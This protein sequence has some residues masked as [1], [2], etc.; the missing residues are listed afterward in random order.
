M[1]QKSVKTAFLQ[2]F[3]KTKEKKMSK[4]ICIEGKS[5]EIV[6][7]KSRFIADVTDIVSEQN[8]LDFIEA[9]KKRYWDARHHCF[10]Y[11]TLDGKTV[12]C[13]D[14]GEPQGTA[15]K[16]MLEVLQH[17]RIAGIC[18]V[19]TRYFGGVL[20]GTGGLI[21]AYQSALIAGLEESRILEEKQGYRLTFCI[22]YEDYG[23]F[24]HLCEKYEIIRESIV[25]TERITIHLVAE[26]EKRAGFLRSLS[27]ESSGKLVPDTEEAI[28]YVA[29]NG[30]VIRMENRQESSKELLI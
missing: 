10:A 26:E 20:L 3:I 19:V 25:Y 13:S 5:G 6:E 1:P 9:V 24:N 17:R 7:K 18:V 29:D 12:R 16:P 22:G 23:R 30:S 21:R 8:A 2:K 11:I 15:G 27:E 4:Y 14:D 28:S